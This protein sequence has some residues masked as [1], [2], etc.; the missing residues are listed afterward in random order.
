MYLVQGHQE[1]LLRAYYTSFPSYL[2]PRFQNE[3]SC[4]TLKTSPICMKISLQM[5]RIFMTMASHETRFDIE[6]KETG[7]WPIS[8]LYFALS[9]HLIFNNTVFIS[10]SGEIKTT[11]TKYKYLEPN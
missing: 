8:L 2:V 4:K 11:N 10:S 5:K 6:A 3:S 7:K 1:N 9:L